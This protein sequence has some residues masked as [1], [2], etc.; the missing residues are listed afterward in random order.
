MINSKTK[1]YG[2]VGYPLGH[3]LSPMIHNTS[4]KELNIN[5]V[6]TPFQVTPDYINILASS[7]K[8]LDIS[9][10]NVTVPYKQDVI[11]QLD[12]ISQ[13]AKLLNSVNTVKLEDGILQG[14]ST[15]YAGFKRKFT[16][17]NIDF[18]NKSILVIGTGGAASAITVGLTIIDDHKSVTIAGRTESKIDSLIDNIISNG[19]LAEKIILNSDEFKEKFSDFDIIIQT[20]SVGMSPKIENSVLEQDMFNKNQIAYDIVY[21]PLVTKFLEDAKKSGAKILTGIDML[22][23]QAAESFKIWTG[24]DIPIE[25]VKNKLSSLGG[26]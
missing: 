12:W 2:I 3:S 26:L 21:N 16:E 22:I 10:I 18:K 20:T 14:Y 6:Y 15:D 9:G 13:E 17:A 1:K 7:M 4:F 19:G 11:S 24:K 8:S 23:Y 25:K 5:A